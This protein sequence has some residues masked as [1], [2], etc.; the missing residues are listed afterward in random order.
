MCY[1]F[2]CRS[3]FILSQ[4]VSYDTDLS[5]N[6]TKYVYIIKRQ[7]QKVDKLSKMI[8]LRRKILLNVCIMKRK[9]HNRLTV[10]TKSYTAHLVGCLKFL[11]D[12]M[13]SKLAASFVVLIFLRLICKRNMSIH[14]VRTADLLKG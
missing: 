1:I 8:P 9:K 7:K 2:M 14:S 10:E 5:E 3:G 6:F 12:V 11:L 13:R 4:A